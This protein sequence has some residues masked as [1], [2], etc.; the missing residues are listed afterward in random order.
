MEKPENP[1]FKYLE[2]GN[3][4]ILWSVFEGDWEDLTPAQ[5]AEVL[6]C[7]PKQ[8]S[9]YIWKIKKKQDT[10]FRIS[11]SEGENGMNKRHYP[12]WGYIRHIIQTYPSRE[13]KDLTG[14]AKREQEAV[15]AAIEAMQLLENRE[16]RLDVIRMVHLD[17]TRT[18]EGAALAVSCNRATAARWQRMFFEEV[19]RNR[20]LLE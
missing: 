15:Q 12:W 19:A 17:K 10:R 2:N 3:I 6:G 20:D 8:V 11:A 9:S 14:V 5:I 13:G 4:S 18:L 7:D 16:A 1:Y